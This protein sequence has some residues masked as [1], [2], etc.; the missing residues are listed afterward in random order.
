MITRITQTFARPRPVALLT[1]GLGLLIL[2]ISAIVAFSWRDN[3]PERVA[4]HWGTSGA[5]QFASPTTAI[6]VPLAIGA[7]LTIGFAAMTALVGQSAA[8]RR[9]SGG[10]SVGIATFLGM[11][12]V[13]TTWAQQA[14]AEP[15]TTDISRLITGAIGGG[16]LLG[17]LIAVALPGDRPQPSASAVDP[18]GERLPLEDSEHAVWMRT[19]Q[20]GTGLAIGIAAA[21]SIVVLAVV[22]QLWAMFLIALL[23]G[24][25]LVAMMSWVVRVDSDGL[26]VR[27]AIGFPRTEVP[28][29]EVE[30]VDVIDVSPMREFGGWGWR[31]GRGGRV[32][33]IVRPG[34]SL[35]VE[36]SGG[37]SI[38]VT[39]DD[40]ATG[41]ALLRT[42]ADR[43]HE[44]R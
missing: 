40:A 16:I 20:G 28:V 44:S 21:A 32:G 6:V 22:T 26:R 19:A 31:V 30:R 24:I 2:A 35:L 39:V 12:T 5:D 36:R 11:L 37:R 14:V 43:A 7:L 42:M 38:V 10:V 4:I 27:S 25:V 29:N 23:L 33:I 15:S 8:T 13:S 9:V 41:A 18:D 34:E 1:G 17:V 3:L